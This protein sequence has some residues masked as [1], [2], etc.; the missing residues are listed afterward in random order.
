MPE[1]AATTEKVAEVPA[2]TVT[3]KGCVE[4]DGGEL[5]VNVAVF[6]IAEAPEWQSSVTTHV[7]VP[8]SEL[9]SVAIVN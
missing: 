8:L 1:P 3:G 6:V 2:V 4:I 9:E 7:Y 5:T